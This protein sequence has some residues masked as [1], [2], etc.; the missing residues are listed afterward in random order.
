MKIRSPSDY[1][2]FNQY[3]THCTEY[4]PYIIHWTIATALATILFYHSPMYKQI[5]IR[6]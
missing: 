1:D 2:I 5:E 4:M 6:E 3:D